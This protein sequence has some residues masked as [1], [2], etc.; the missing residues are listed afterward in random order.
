MLGPSIIRC[1]VSFLPPPTSNCHQ[2]KL[3]TQCQNRI[4]VH[5]NL[6][7]CNS[8]FFAR[9]KGAKWFGCAW[10]KEKIGAKK[11]QQKNR[12]SSLTRG[13]VGAS[14]RLFSQVFLSLCVLFGRFDADGKFIQ[15]YT[16]SLSSRTCFECVCVCAFLF[17][18]H[19]SFHSSI[20]FLHWLFAVFACGVVLA[21][22]CSRSKR[23]LKRMFSV[24]RLH[25][26]RC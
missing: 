14:L 7:I 5:T 15:I 17:F 25:R 2:F 1:F 22:I 10:L 26:V 13:A 18:L 24:F 8:S 16:S 3:E 4:K 19:T 11:K 20:F 6:S 12:V 21:L 9:C 23:A